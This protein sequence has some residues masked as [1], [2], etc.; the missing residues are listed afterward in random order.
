VSSRRLV[1]FYKK[2][3]AP[4]TLEIKC[5]GLKGYQRSGVEPKRYSRHTAS[6]PYTQRKAPSLTLDILDVENVKDVKGM[7]GVTTPLSSIFLI[8]RITGFL[9]SKERK[10]I[11]C[12]TQKTQPF[13]RRSMT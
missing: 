1:E 12:L 6:S 13:S 3:F 10:N 11:R 4:D 7:P 9:L 8:S 2:L 5:R